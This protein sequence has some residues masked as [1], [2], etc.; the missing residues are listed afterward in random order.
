M[1]SLALPPSGRSRSHVRMPF[2]TAFVT[3]TQ[4]SGAKAFDLSALAKDL[5]AL[6]WAWVKV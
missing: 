2:G 3:M 6:D 4:F 5:I 1:M